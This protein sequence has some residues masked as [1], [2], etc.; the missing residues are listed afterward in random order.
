M[1]DSQAGLNLIIALLLKKIQI[2]KYKEL[3]CQEHM[4][5]NT[6]GFE[7]TGH[8]KEIMALGRGRHKQYGIRAERKHPENTAVH[9]LTDE[10]GKAKLNM[11]HT[12]QEIIR[13]KQET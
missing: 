9:N 11:M 4:Y 1:K 6:E 2:T 5:S 12:G 7:Q 13:I 10:T 3:N 8:K